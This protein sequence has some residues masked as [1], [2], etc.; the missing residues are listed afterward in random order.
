MAFR[1]TL[2]QHPILSAPSWT[3]ERMHVL[4]ML[5]VGLEPKQIEQVIV[6]RIDIAASVAFQ[7]VRVAT[8]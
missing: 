5:L 7:H 3:R 8:A 2:L 1:S 6:H 4:T